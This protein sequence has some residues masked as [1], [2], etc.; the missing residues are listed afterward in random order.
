LESFEGLAATN[1]ATQNTITVTD[2]TI[3]DP[4][5]TELGVFDNPGSFGP[6]DGLNY[7]LKQ[8]ND[9]SEPNTITITFNS[10]INAFG[11]F[12][13]D[14]CESFP[15]T[16][17]FSNDAGDAFTA[18]TGPL[19]NATVFFGVINWDNVFTQ[20][21]LTNHT[22]D[23]FGLDK[24]HYGTAVPEPSIVLLLGAGL[25]GLVALRRKRKSNAFP[26][27]QQPGADC[28]AVFVFWDVSETG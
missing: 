2:F 7:V 4:N 11:L 23:W 1:A 20:V 6:V 3:T 13:T 28:S 25:L 21:V 26:V 17:A 19:D 18:V 9:S 14:C 27:T 24:V 22:F 15:Y 12:I 10:P 5:K 8:D 16:L